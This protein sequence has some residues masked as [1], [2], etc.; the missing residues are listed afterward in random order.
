MQSRKARPK[1]RYVHA[2]V[3]LVENVLRFNLHSRNMLSSTKYL[4]ACDK[5]RSLVDKLNSSEATNPAF[6][7]LDSSYLLEEN[8]LRRHVPQE[9]TDALAQF[10]IVEYVEAVPVVMKGA[11]PIY[12]NWFDARNGVVIANMNDKPKDKAPDDE[13][14][15]P[16]EIIWQSWCRV[17]HRQSIP[18]S[19]LRVIVRLVVVNDA[20]RRVIKE[21]LLHSSCTREESTHFEYTDGVPGLLCVAGKR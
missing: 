5:G 21:T 3:N 6:P 4:A 18:V 8:K 15:F 17:A 20:S 12:L 1:Q 7:S 10:G 16:S 11:D 14:L 13:R 19:N 2:I 9:M